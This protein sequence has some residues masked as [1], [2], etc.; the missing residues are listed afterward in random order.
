MKSFRNDVIKSNSEWHMR[1]K[2]FRDFY[3]MSMLRDLLFHVQEHQFT[4]PQ[5]KSCL[6]E[7]GL[8]FCGFETDIIVKDFKQT[9]SETEDPYNLDK[10]HSYEE[11]NPDIFVGMYQFW[12]QKVA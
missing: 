12:C 11:A 10:W 9:N 8:K 1:I 5:I 7:L 3:S 4:L 6:A 2:G